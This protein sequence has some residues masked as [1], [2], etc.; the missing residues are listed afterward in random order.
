MDNISNWFMH[1]GPL[2]RRFPSEIPVASIGYMAHKRDWVRRRFDSYNFSFLLGGGGEYWRDGVQW[3][4]QAPCVITQA[5]GVMMEYGPAGT[6]TEWEELFLIYDARH[7]GALERM[8][9]IREGRP[10]W[11]MGD[12]GPVRSRIRELTRLLGEGR[13]DGLADRVDR[14]CELLVVESL[15]GV[16]EASVLPE[17]QAILAIREHVRASLDE[18]HDFHGLARRYGLSASTFRR[19]WTEVVGTTPGRYVMKLRME[20]ACRLLVETREKIG[21]IAGTLGFDDALYFSRRF[22]LET[23]TTAEAYRRRHQVALPPAGILTPGR[24]P[25]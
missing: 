14:E 8:G 1:L 12:P 19:R 25:V 16:A 22:K 2:P 18:R 5:P 10:M 9:A 11:A 20:E 17:R 23:G 13:Q 24:R 15:M 4:V 7:M 3:R 6:W 21:T